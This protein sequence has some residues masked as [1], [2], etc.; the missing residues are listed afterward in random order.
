MDF[1]Q[2]FVNCGWDNQKQGDLTWRTGLCLVPF[3]NDYCM[4]PCYPLQNKWYWKET[5]YFLV[6]AWE[7]G[8]EHVPWKLSNFIMFAGVRSCYDEGKRT[9][10]TLAMDYH[11]G[12]L[13]NVCFLE[14]FYKFVSIFILNTLNF[15]GDPWFYLW[16]A[17]YMV[18]KLIPVI[19]NML[20]LKVSEY[21]H[22]CCCCSKFSSV[23]FLNFLLFFLGLT[24]FFPYLLICHQIWNF[25]QLY[26]VF[27]SIASMDKF[28]VLMMMFSTVFV[29][30]SSLVVHLTSFAVQ[31]ENIFFMSILELICILMGHLLSFW[32]SKVSYKAMYA[33]S[34]CPYFQHLWP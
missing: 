31:D 18:L 9:A 20:L 11:R 26:L 7:R 21:V 4:I 30:N 10:E 29:Q 6:L 22:D 33:G 8:L 17:I 1:I 15:A 28:L 13:V 16:L 25:S 27:S 23:F 3:C 32:M 12:E 2:Y 14:L 34:H 5:T 24:S 19:S